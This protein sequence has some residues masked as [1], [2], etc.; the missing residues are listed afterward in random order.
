VQLELP[1]GMAPMLGGMIGQAMRG[2]NGRGGREVHIRAANSRGP[3][4][5]PLEDPLAPRR[6]P[7]GPSPDRDSAIGNLSAL[8]VPGLLA[9]R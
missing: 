8:V 4:G 9:A 2:Q 1:A 5:V 3:P 7:L 6:G